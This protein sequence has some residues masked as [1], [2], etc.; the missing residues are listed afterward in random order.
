VDI[1]FGDAGALNTNSTG[2]FIGFSDWA[3]ANAPGVTDLRFKAKNSL[4][5]A[6]NVKWMAQKM[7]IAELQSRPVTVGPSRSW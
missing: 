3:K 6:V 4:A 7:T 2:W 5:H 1:E